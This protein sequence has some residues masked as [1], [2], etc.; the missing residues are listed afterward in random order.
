MTRI[1]I[2]IPDDVVEY[3]RNLPDLNQIVAD[4]IRLRAAQRKVDN[5]S[6]SPKAFVKKWL[7]VF[8]GK[9][10]SE[11]PRLSYLTKKYLS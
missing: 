11:D 3:A 5:S 4:A 10:D 8:A 1:T 2:E 9:A 6:I 7:G